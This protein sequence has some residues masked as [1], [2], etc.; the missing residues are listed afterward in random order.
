[1]FSV[2]KK[3]NNTFSD[4]IKYVIQTSVFVLLF[5]CGTIAYGYPGQDEYECKFYNAYITG[6]MSEW[7]DWIDQMENIYSDKRNPELLY[8]IVEAYYGYVGYLIGV[9]R[10]DVASEYIE[11]GEVYL[12]KLKDIPSYKS[13]YEALQGAF[14][15]FKIGLNKSKAIWLGPRS[16]KHINNAV[17]QDSANPIAWVEK[18]NAE[19]HMPRIFGGSYRKAVTYYQKAVRYY[20]RQNMVND[21]N[22]VYMN[23]LAWLAKSCEKA[24]MRDK[25]KLTYLKI[26]DREPDFKWVKEEL[27]PEFKEN[28]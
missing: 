19:Y 12:E 7:A 25:A 16:M 6:D 13:R 11:S 15:A 1:M 22:W 18:A 27:Y 26:L 4:M 20:Q 3:N 2:L 24:D 14:I 10:D 5:L 23:A 8:D 21:C 17:K 28:Q 9:D